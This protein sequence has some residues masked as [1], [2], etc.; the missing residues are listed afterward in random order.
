M[1]RTEAQK[2]IKDLTAMIKRHIRL[3]WEENNPE[4]T[5]TAYDALIKRLEDIENNYPDSR[6]TCEEMVRGNDGKMRYVKPMR[7]GMYRHLHN[8]LKKH[9]N[10]SNLVYLCMER[11]D[12]WDRIMGF[13]PDSPGH[14]DFLFA[15]NMH[16]R[17]G[18]GPGVP[19]REFY[20]HKEDTVSP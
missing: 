11:R 6:L 19:V 5:D 3:Y 8:E 13:H 16:K 1:D 18:T 2:Q 7:L 10:V 14:L 17:F 9:I 20:E 12:V 4:I 15:E